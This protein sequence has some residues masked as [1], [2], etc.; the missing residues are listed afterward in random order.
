MTVYLTVSTYSTPR[1][2]INCI[3]ASKLSGTTLTVLVKN[4]PLNFSF[5]LFFALKFFLTS[6][7]FFASKCFT[8]FFFHLIDMLRIIFT[9]KCL[10]V[11]FAKFSLFYYNFCSFNDLFSRRVCF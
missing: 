9:Y 8:L 4:Q 11:L 3:N 10:F 5:S 2:H 6:K 1:V 7:D